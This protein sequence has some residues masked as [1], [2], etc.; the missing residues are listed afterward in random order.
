VD[1]LIIRTSDR[2][3]FKRCR[4][5]WDFTSKIRMDYEPLRPKDYFEFGTAWHAAMESW[6]A[7]EHGKNEDNYPFLDAQREQPARWAFQQTN[8]QQRKQLVNLGFGGQEL[9]QEYQEREVLGLNMLEYYFGWSREHD[10]FEPITVEHEFEVLIGYLHDEHFRDWDVGD[11]RSQ[12]VVYQG[13]I[14]GLVRDLKGNYWLLEHKTASKE[15]GTQWLMMDEQTGS[16]IWAFEKML[17]VRILGVIRTVAYKRF[18][19]QPRILKDGGVSVD[20]R[21]STTAQLF[22]DAVQE[23]YP[24]RPAP[25]TIAKVPKYKEYWDFLFSEAA[26]VF[27]ERH[28]LTRNHEQIEDIGRRITLEAE[29]MLSDPHIY[30]NVSPMNCNPCLFFGPCLMRQEGSDW[31]F[32]L[33]SSY[34]KRSDG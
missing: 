25:E 14:D 8:S 18:P 7:P 1:K 24:F 29:D 6:Y 15:G 21:Q 2:Q 12:E 19:A 30:P 5:L 27:V 32:T 9:D 20:R 22:M 10:D 16:Y 26:P 13:R 33:K 23:A 17:G 34:R 28:S 11:G 4:Q 3:I 31:E